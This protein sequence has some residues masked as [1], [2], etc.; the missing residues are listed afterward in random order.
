MSLQRRNRSLKNYDEKE[1]QNYATC[2]THYDLFVF[3]FCLLFY[4]SESTDDIVCFVVCRR[5]RGD[6]CVCV[7][8][9]VCVEILERNKLWLGCWNQ[10]LLYVTMVTMLML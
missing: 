10:T 5:K 4:A 9:C 3:S 7:S 6:V 2:F 1:S 8:V